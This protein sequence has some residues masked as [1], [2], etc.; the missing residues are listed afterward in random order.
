MD[1][2]DFES[3]TSSKNPTKLFDCFL[4]SGKKFQDGRFR[5]RDYI[6]RTKKPSA[7]FNHWQFIPS[8]IDRNSNRVWIFF[9]LSGFCFFPKK[10]KPSGYSPFY[11]T[12][13]STA[14]FQFESS[15]LC[16]MIVTVLHTK[17]AQFHTLDSYD[18]S[19]PN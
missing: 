19:K 6:T 8:I 9:S 17:H 1:H 4:R 16:E 18:L 14:K 13:I 7:N 3:L 2:D 11:V 10:R 12:I 5:T 15:D